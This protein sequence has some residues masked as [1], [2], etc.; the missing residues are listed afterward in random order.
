V[1]QRRNDAAAVL[2]AVGAVGSP[3]LKNTDEKR[4]QS[5]PVRDDPAIG[6][7]LEQACFAL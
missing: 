3:T 4:R 2:G 7:L 5:S 1:Q 6:T